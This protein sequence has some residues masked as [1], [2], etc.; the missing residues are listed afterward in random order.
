[1]KFVARRIQMDHGNFL[2]SPF[3]KID[4]PVAG[5]TATI[6]RGINRH[7]IVV[8]LY[9]DAAGRH[10]FRYNPSSGKYDT[11]DVP[12][13]FVANERVKDSN[14][15]GINDQG[16]I[17]GGLV[18]EKGEYGY[19]LAPITHGGPY[20]ASPDGP[21]PAPDLFRLV[22]LRL[23]DQEL[24]A[25]QTGN[26]QTGNLTNIGCHATCIS[27]DMDI[28]GRIF[29]GVPFNQVVTTEVHGFVLTGGDDQQPWKEYRRI[30]VSDTPFTLT[31]IYGINLYRGDVGRVIDV[32]GVT[33]FP[34]SHAF[35]Q[36][37][38]INAQFNVTDNIDPF[39]QKTTFSSGR[40]ISS[41]QTVVGY[42]T[43]KVN[44]N[45]MSDGLGFVWNLSE[46]SAPI[47][48]EVWTAKDN[49]WYSLWYGEAERATST[50]AHGI[51]DDGY[52]VGEYKDKAGTIHGFVLHPGLWHLWLVTQALRKVQ[53]QLPIKL[54]PMP[55]PTPVPPWLWRRHGTD[56]RRT[57][58][59][60]I[61]RSTKPGNNLDDAS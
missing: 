57:V 16:Y 58:S 2:P 19:R 40:G 51:N 17:V 48:I 50:Y 49:D 32:V 9:K 54:P 18:T 35:V 28:G 24:V 7:G 26:L 12:K 20:R 3:H 36:K 27:N 39:P 53:G 11:F 15:A 8:G 55:P 38:V 44:G 33:N 13:D 37:N 6:A 4:V 21:S 41:N 42:Y 14:A 61:K 25:K 56:S 43:E 23:E 47:P 46:G 52:I 30:D 5:V 1:V 22:D 34:Q 31:E 60:A 59:R 29:I 10:G 45:H